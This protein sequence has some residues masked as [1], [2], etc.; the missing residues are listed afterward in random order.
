MNDAGLRLVRASVA[1]NLLDPTYD[2]RGVRWLRD[3]GGL[4][5]AFERVDDSLPN[6]DRARSPFF[7]LVEGGRTMLRRRLDASYRRGE[8]PML[9]RFQREGATDYAAPSSGSAT[10]PDSRGSPTRRAPTSCS[11]C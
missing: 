10:S 11:R 8:F 7:A 3:G 6:E 4:E 9:D 2:A 1:N 5:E